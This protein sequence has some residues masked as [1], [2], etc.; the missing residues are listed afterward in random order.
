MLISVMSISILLSLAKR[1]KAS[2]PLE[3]QITSTK[4][5]QHIL[6]DLKNS[7]II[8]YNKCNSAHICELHK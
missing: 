5:L 3:A 1:A 7:R 6:D 8:V 2:A 4:I